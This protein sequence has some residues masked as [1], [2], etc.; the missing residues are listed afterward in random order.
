MLKNEKRKIFSDLENLESEVEDLG[1]KNDELDKI[2]R[3][4]DSENQQLERANSQF[5]SSRNNV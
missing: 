1:F 5:N 3:S 4:L 2:V